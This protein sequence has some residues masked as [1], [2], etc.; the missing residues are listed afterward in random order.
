MAKG[1][2]TPIHPEKYLGDPTKI[3]FLSAWELRFMQFCDKNPD[4]TQWGSEEFKIPYFN[5]VKRKVCMYIPDFIVRYRKGDKIITEVI[6][7][8]PAKE[9][10]LKPK[11]SNYDKVC[12]VINTAK[13]Q[14]ARIYCDKYGVTFRILT[15]RGSMTVDQKGLPVVLTEQ[16]LFKK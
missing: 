12:L 16:G 10:V 6:E 8:K 3:R 14:S 11:M 4:V 5:P 9:A 13:W 7:I 1:L 15:E 2:Y